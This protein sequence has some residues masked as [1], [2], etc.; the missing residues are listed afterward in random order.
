MKRRNFLKSVLGV[1]VAPSICAAR[2]SKQFKFPPTGINFNAIKINGTFDEWIESIRVEV[3]RLFGSTKKR[4]ERYLVTT[5]WSTWG[6]KTP[7]RLIIISDFYNKNIGWFSFA[8]HE[9]KRKE[10]NRQKNL[11]RLVEVRFIDMI[12]SLHDHIID[13]YKVL[14]R[15]DPNYRVENYG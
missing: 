2:S 15:F 3:E 4:N 12:W 13:H 6:Y 10:R 14:K 8:E 1:A 11:T 5:K 7:S 9:F